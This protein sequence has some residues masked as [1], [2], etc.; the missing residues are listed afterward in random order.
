MTGQSE[1]P[2]RLPREKRKAT[3]RP[4]AESARS[5]HRE[6]RATILLNF[7]SKIAAAELYASKDALDAIL[8][9]LRAEE[10]AALGALREREHIRIR[11][12]TL[13]RIAWRI[14][15]RVSIRPRPGR[16]PNRPRRARRRIRK[17]DKNL[18]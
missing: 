12:Q 18:S 2:S 15:E 6:E 1:R 9:A 10:Q 14:A 8:A 7:A 11:Q 16:D 17:R 3:A 13:V 5:T 4:K